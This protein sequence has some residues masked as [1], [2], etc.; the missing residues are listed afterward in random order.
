MSKPN[1]LRNSTFS[2]LMQRNFMACNQVKKYLL[3]LLILFG[4]N[5]IV[6]QEKPISI[7]HNHNAIYVT[8][9]KAA[10]KFYSTIIGLD[11][12]PEPFRLGR[13]IWYKIS[14]HGQ[15]H[16]IAGAKEK[17]E[18]YKNQHTCFSVSDFKAFLQKLEVN[19]IPYEDVAG[20]KQSFTT[21]VDGVH[22]IWIQDPDGYWIEI[23]DAR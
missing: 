1:H 23:N 17:K 8:D 9:L 12:I 6:A 11:S 16:V 20:K 3:A 15:L 4:S 22:Q 2:S 10:G 18:Y 14:E 21:R 19:A 7:T 13:H 5:S